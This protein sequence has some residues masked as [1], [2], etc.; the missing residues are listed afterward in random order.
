MNARA[1]RVFPGLQVGSVS[2]TSAVLVSTGVMSLGLTVA[3]ARDL[4]QRIA[5]AADDVEYNLSLR[6]RLRHEHSDQT[7][8]CTFQQQMEHETGKPSS[9]P[10]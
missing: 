5:R 7:H 3:E 9:G 10:L 1:L 6:A 4:A 8:A 2:D